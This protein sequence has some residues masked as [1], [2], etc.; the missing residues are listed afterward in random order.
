MH[1]VYRSRAII[2]S[3]YDF[4]DYDKDF[5]MLTE[6]FGLIR[7]RAQGIRRMSSKMRYSLQPFS[8]TDI[9]LVRGKYGF[10]ITNSN[11]QKNFFYENKDF[12]FV[13]MISKIF[14]LLKRLIQGDDF[15]EQT[16]K[17]FKETID[18]Y[19][20]LEKKDRTEN[21]L[22]SLEIITVLKILFYLGYVKKD[23]EF[24]GI[25]E[26]KLD[27]DILNSISDESLQKKLI[28]QINNS[29]KESQL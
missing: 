13:R 16:F 25:I 5:L 14:N 10:R 27:L 17:I 7:G 6:K 4:K 19:D 21:L 9:A 2:I 26:N 20:S 24:L 15:S 8:L 29:I 28:K 1:H 22:K 3:D 23:K 18:F 12:G 11:I